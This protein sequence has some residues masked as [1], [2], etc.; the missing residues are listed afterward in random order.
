MGLLIVPKDYFSVREQRFRLGNTLRE[1]HARSPRLC[2]AF[3]DVV[4]I[5]RYEARVRHRGRASR[6]TI[7]HADRDRSVRIQL[8]PVVALQLLH[9]L[10]TALLLIDVLEMELLNALFLHRTARRERLG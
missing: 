5:E 10:L 1:E 3:F 9:R 4:A 8:H 6:T 2:I 7:V